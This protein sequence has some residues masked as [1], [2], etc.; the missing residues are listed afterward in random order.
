[1]TPDDFRR[2]FPAFT[3]LSDAIINP[4]ITAMAGIFQNPGLF[5]VN[6]ALAQGNVV[7]HLIVT[8]ETDDGMDPGTND[9]VNEDRASLKRLRDA[10]LLRI[11]SVD[12]FMKT[13]FG[14][15]FRYFSRRYGAG[16]RAA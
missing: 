15:M 16:G 12:P 10:Y 4:Q 3:D 6:V 9:N 13:K 1:M 11:Q 14:Q 5:G 7:A 8:N 2:A